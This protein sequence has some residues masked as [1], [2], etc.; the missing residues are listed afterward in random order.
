MINSMLYITMRL[1]AMGVSP[2]AKFT[3]AAGKK[4]R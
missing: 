2:D 4:V 3:A 1:R